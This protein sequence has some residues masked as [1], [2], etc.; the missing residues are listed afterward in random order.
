MKRLTLGIIFWTIITAGFAYFY[1]QEKSAA[2]AA[3]NQLA[4]FL[5]KPCEIVELE[6][7]TA[8]TYK[9]GDR[10]FMFDS[11]SNEATQIG[12]IVRVESLSSTNMDLAFGKKAF[13]KLFPN[14]PKITGKDFFTYH[15]TPDSMEW[16]IEQMLPPEKRKA[17]AEKL[18]ATYKKN[19]TE[20]NELLKPI[21][22]KS[23]AESVV[24]IQADLKVALDKRSDEIRE[25]GNRLQTDLVKE[26]LVP[27][28][29]EEIW[30]V[31]KTE[32]SP[33]LNTVGQEMWK[34]VSVWRFGWR[35]L[36]DASPLPERDLTKKE[37]NRF[38]EN[39]GISILQNHA[40]DFLEVQKT[41]L[42][43]ISENETVQTVV[44]QSVSEFVNDEEVQALFT[45]IFQEVVVNNER[46][47]LVWQQ[48]WNS[49]EAQNAIALASSRMKP[50][51]EDIG[52]AMFG[53]PREPIP[54]EFARVLRNRILFKDNRWMTLKHH[55]GE[56]PLTDD[57]TVP[58]IKAEP[59]PLQNN[60]FHTPTK[61]SQ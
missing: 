38:L 50:T 34:E 33:V 60:P 16:V 23:I 35:Y 31:I 25:I 22:K 2:K 47:H 6:F 49:E 8:S 3:T 36:Y 52:Q 7:E 20:L 9:V 51:V 61:S 26:D 57:A 54:P 10:I 32:V 39:H 24:V 14:A 30:P 37:F 21:I 28:I 1:S 56:P 29:Q 12:M 48:N 11:E 44:S 41:V 4:D 13:A 18:V 53:N 42:R 55:P 5:F 46:L 45:K 43:R 27:L 19:Q 58:V 59:E 15:D 40:D 17:Y